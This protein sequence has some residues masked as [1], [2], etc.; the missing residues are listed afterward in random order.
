V[1]LGWGWKVVRV[2]EVLERMEGIRG[3]FLVGGLLCM[4]IL[5][6]R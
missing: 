5:G 6:I 2:R 4:C 3:W 1:V